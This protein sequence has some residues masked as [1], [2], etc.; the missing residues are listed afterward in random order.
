MI[1]DSIARSL[2]A[3]T[4]KDFSKSHNL[5][6]NAKPTL[7]KIFSDQWD[8]FLN[9]PQVLERGLRDTTS[10]EV[11]KMIDC[12]T[13]N[14]GFELYECPNCNQAHAICYTCKSR[15]FPS[16]GVKYAKQRAYNISKNC[17]DVSHRHVVF[18]MDN[19][20]REF[21]LKDRSILNILFKSVKETLFYT[22]NKM[23]SK[24][25]S[26]TPGIIMNIHTFGRALNWNPHVHCLVTEGGI[27]NKHVYQKID[28]IHYETL[29]KSFMRNLTKNIK[30][31]L[32]THTKEYLDI[33]QL[34]RVMYKEHKNGFYV[35][36]PSVKKQKDYDALIHYIVRYTGRPVMAQ[37]R[38]IDYNKEKKTIQYYY[39][40]HLTDEKVIVSEHVFTFMKKLIIHIPATIFK[41]IRY[42]GIY[43]TVNHRHKKKVK[44]IILKSDRITK[45]S[46]PYRR[47][48]ILILILIFGVD[49]LLCTCGHYMEFIGY[50]IPLSEGRN[51]NGEIHTN[52]MH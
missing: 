48:L 7:Q 37:S 18:T 9:D 28:Y 11:L 36:A 50:Y 17:L 47:D 27:N 14:S 46:L 31:S 42:C 43:A 20:L 25:D 32:Q 22:F 44:A 35:H 24:N 30:D 23:N 19:R 13:F 12:G 45:N 49:P 33:S 40:D 29:R 51:K 10:K 34:I 52:E 3:I 2:Y 15:F 5:H 39:E 41:M 21:F 26:F 6:L 1:S 16:C 4:T 8:D 38:I